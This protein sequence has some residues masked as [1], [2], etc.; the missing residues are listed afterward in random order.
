MTEL[1]DASQIEQL[2]GAQRH[3]EEHFGRADS[4]TSTVYILH[5]EACLSSTPDLRDCEYSI[6]LAQGI[7]DFYPWMLWEAAQDR[8]VA[9]RI[10][11]GY[12][13]PRITHT[14][15]TDA[16]AAEEGLKP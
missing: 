11:R 1:V 12:L 13:V 10:A 14:T 8:P 7:Q 3:P 5:S 4:E 9:L 6:A 16:L 2:V 15:N